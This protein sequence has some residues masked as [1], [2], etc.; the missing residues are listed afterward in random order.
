MRRGS[1]EARWWRRE[2]DD[3]DGVV[4][5]GDAARRAGETGLDE[6]AMRR[7]GIAPRWSVDDGRWEKS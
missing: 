1:I 4:D 6:G 7:R 2:G 3:A 5:E